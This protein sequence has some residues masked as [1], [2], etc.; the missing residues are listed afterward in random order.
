MANT[1]GKAFD[2]GLFKRILAY[3][4]PYKR[5]FYFVAFSAIML[6]GLG[7]LRPYFLRWAIDNGIVPKDM[8][9]LFFI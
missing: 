6:S 3:T 4:N 7:V 2:M 1:T 5:T 8:D 9:E